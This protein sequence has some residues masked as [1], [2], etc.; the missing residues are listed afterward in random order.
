MKEPLNLPKEVWFRVEDR[1]FASLDEFEDALPGRVYVELY[2][3]EVISHTPKG[4][5]VYDYYG[6]PKFVL[7]AARKRWACP[8]KE[9]AIQSFLARKERQ[10]KIL[11]NQLS[12]AT[13]AIQLA[14]QMKNESSP[15]LNQTT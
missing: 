15:C 12:Q 9:E 5:W 4:V 6:H 7:R 8:T 14:K 2:E 10:I 13:T 1:R 3:Y 11:R